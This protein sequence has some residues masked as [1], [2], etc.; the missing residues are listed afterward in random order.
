MLSKKITKFLVEK[1]KNVKRL[2]KLF[3]SV[4][5]C[6]F[7][8]L[9]LILF[10]QVALMGKIHPGITISGNKI[11]NLTKNEAKNILS[12]SIQPPEEIVL[13]NKD[14]KYEIELKNFD[15]EYDYETSIQNA[16]KFTR[17]GNLVYDFTKTIS[18]FFRKENL[19]LESSIN[20]ERFEDYLE[21]LNKELTI[22][23]V[24]PKI[25]LENEHIVVG[26]GEKGSSLDFYFLRSLIYSNLSFANNKEIEIPFF[27]TGFTLKQEEIKVAKERGEKFLNKK[28][29]L[30]FKDHH[31][32]FE[33]KNLVSFIN[34]LGEYYEQEIASEI[35]NISLEI[36]KN[37]QNS[38]FVF[39]KNRVKEFKPSKDGYEVEKENLKNM[40]V[41]NLRTI[42]QSEEKNISFQI[43]V[44][45]SSPEIQTK[46]VNNLGI[47]TLLGRGT[48]TFYG[49]IANRIYNIGHASAKF[50]GVLVA[51]GEVFSFNKTLGEVSPETGYKQAYIIKE[52]KTILGDGGGVCQVSTTFFRAAMKAGLPILE[53]QAHAYRVGYYEQDSS[54]GLDATVYEPSPDLKIRN[55]TSKHILIQ[56]VFNQNARSLAFEI[57]GTDDG[58]K[59]SISKPIVTNVTPPP[60]D[61]Y[62][63][64][65]TLPIGQIKQT[66]YKAWGAKAKFT[67]NVTRNGVNIYKKTFYSN[68]KPWQAIF[69]RGTQPIQ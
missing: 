63:D 64:D 53:R 42:E 17:T 34:P 37:P 69:L 46:D 13:K 33:D 52:G 48:S 68:Y 51:P 22:A 67:Y 27:E 14:Q 19:G 6:L 36:D 23:P 61:L 38:V 4:T 2:K 5:L 11:G 66:E 12:S 10:L 32:I 1:L 16:Y 39:E 28:L 55:D 58:R 26:K 59:A 9:I 15:F 8:I 25:L 44:E 45:I 40:F 30:T 3:L 21:T 56:S 31:F 49:S 50:Q 24:L 62:I 65:P 47:E 35:S 20:E 18:L 57:Y 60:E 54:P 41:G 43:P 7:L 29:S